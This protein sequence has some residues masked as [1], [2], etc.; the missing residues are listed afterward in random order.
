[1]GIVEIHD[2]TIFFLNIPS[3]KRGHESKRTN[4]PRLFFCGSSEKTGAVWNVLTKGCFNSFLRFFL[5]RCSSTTFMLFTMLTV[6][7]FWIHGRLTVYVASPLWPKLSRRTSSNANIQHIRL[8]YTIYASVTV[9]QTA[10][11]PFAEQPIATSSINISIFANVHV[12]RAFWVRLHPEWHCVIFS[13]K[14][15][16]IFPPNSPSKF[17]RRCMYAYVRVIDMQT[18]KWDYTNLKTCKQ[19]FSCDEFGSIFIPIQL[20]EVITLNSFPKKQQNYSVLFFGDVKGR[21]QGRD[22]SW[23]KHAGTEPRHFSGH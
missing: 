23:F 11:D 16:T 20:S 1:M 13:D 10:H 15:V 22:C 18:S 6:R 8:E 2:D 17:A 3:T 19:K 5:W 9:V 4:W 7:G 21:V 12:C 14:K